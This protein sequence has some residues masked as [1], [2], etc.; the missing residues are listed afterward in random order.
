MKE[1]DDK[2]R[3]N[4]ARKAS[5]KYNQERYKQKNKKF[6]QKTSDIFQYKQEKKEVK[7][8][9]IKGEK[10]KKEKIKG[11]SGTTYKKT[12]EAICF[13]CGKIYANE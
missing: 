7:E 3:K 6:Q 10:I 13:G 12:K 5:A 1:F 8:E 11:E 2:Q 9:K 4:F